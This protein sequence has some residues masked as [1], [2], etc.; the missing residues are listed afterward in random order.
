MGAVIQND[1]GLA[2]WAV[3]IAAPTPLATESA[4]AE[5]Q[6]IIVEEIAAATT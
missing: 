3:S 5:W 1:S 4:I 2:A 6:K